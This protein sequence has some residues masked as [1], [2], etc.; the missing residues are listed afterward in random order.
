MTTTKTKHIVIGGGLAGLS[1]AYH[2]VQSG[3]P[4]V[5]IEKNQCGAM[6]SRKAAGMITPASEVFLEE[7]KLLETFMDC[8]NYYPKFISQLTANQPQT[9]DFNQNGS[10][11]CATDGDGVKE[12]RRLHQFQKSMGLQV[13]ELTQTQTKKMEPYLSSHIRYATHA[14][15]ESHVDN[16]KLLETLKTKLMSSSLCDIREH[17]EITA[18]STLANKITTVVTHQETLHA[19]SV[20]LTT[21]LNTQ[22]NG[23]ESLSEQLPMRPVKGQVMVVQSDTPILSRPL[24]IY[25]RYHIYVVPR[26]DGRIVIGATSEELS[27]D[28]ITAGG[29]LDLIYAAWQALPL[30]YG[31][32]CCGNKSWFASCHT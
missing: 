6:A 16:V 7:Q 20:F 8:A 11:M 9:V 17:T 21:G 29:L 31:I 24:R 13:Q 22:I 5:L 19:R 1:V 32:A 15:N 26:L 30:V 23:L 14:P 10:I 2:L 4:V 28:Q 3:E 25:H 27:D 18:I 12:L